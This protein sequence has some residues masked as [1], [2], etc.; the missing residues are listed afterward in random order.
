VRAMRV[1]R[2]YVRSG[3]GDGGAGYLFFHSPTI[4]SFRAGL[5]A[6][7]PAKGRRSDEKSA[8]KED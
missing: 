3:G 8:Q 2:F 7:E 4:P 1:T 6:N 5:I